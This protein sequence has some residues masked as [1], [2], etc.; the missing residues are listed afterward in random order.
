MPRHSTRNADSDEKLQTVCKDIFGGAANKIIG[1]LNSSDDEGAITLTQRALLKS[2]ILLIPEAERNVKD[3]GGARGVYAYNSL[4]SQCREL[5][6]DLTA[7]QDAALIASSINV[8][9]VQPAFISMVQYMVD[10][11]YRLKKD[12]KD[13]LPAENV[14]KANELIDGT[15]KGLARYFQ[16]QCKDVQVKIERRLVD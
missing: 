12:L 16:E 3:S 10:A 6:A 4:V 13:L 14:R 8:G 1:L 15:A 5:L 9:T 2:T 7:S 11:N